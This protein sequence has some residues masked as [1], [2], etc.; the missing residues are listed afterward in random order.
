MLTLH[1]VSPSGRDRSCDAAAGLRRPAP[2]VAAALLGLTL[3]LAAPAAADPPT[4]NGLFY[5]DGDSSKYVEY[6]T[7]YLGS[8]L[9]ISYDAPTATLYTALVV[10][11]NV[12]DNVFGQPDGGTTYMASVGW[13]NGSGQQ[14]GA[15]KL[16][17]SEFAQFTFACAPGSPNQWTWYQ[18]Y[19]CLSGGSW[20]S[21]MSC[22][23]SSGAAPP[24]YTSASS[25]AWN[26]NTYQAAP[27]PKPWNREVRGTRLRDWVSPFD[28]AQT[29]PLALGLDGY[30][31][32]A[33]AGFSDLYQYEWRMVY[34]WSVPLGPGGADCGGNLLYV[35]TGLSHHSPLK[36]ELGVPPP[37]C[38]D[39]END[40][41][42]G[43]I[44]TADPLSDWGD[45]PDGYGT[46]AASG[47]PYHI[48][49]VNGPYLGQEIVFELDGQ[50]S[51]DGLGDGAEEDGV[52]A[53]IDGNWTVGSIR[54]FEVEVS[55]AASGALLG[56][57]LDW[58]GDGDVADAGEFYSW[59]VVEGTNTLA[60]TVGSGFD[61]AV[62]TLHAR[63]RLFSG[64]AAAPGGSLDQSDSIGVATDGEVEDWVWNP[65]TLPVT[66]NAF[67]SS[68]SPD[69]E[70]T[71]SWQT[72]SE[73]DNVG[74]E[75]WGLAGDGW[76]RLG[77][78]VPSLDTESHL[79]TDY[80]VAVA[81]PSGLTH[82]Q[83]VDFST[84][85]AVEEY[86]PFRLGRR[87]GEVQPVRRVDWAP[88]RLERERRLADRGF[89]PV[90]GG[91]DGAQVI[92]KRVAA[93]GAGAAPGGREGAVREVGTADAAGVAKRTITV[94]EGPQTHIAVTE[95]GIQRVTYETLRD[96][97][98]DLAGVPS[99][100]IAV[101]RRGSP[102]A[103][104]VD[105]GKVFGPGSAIEFVGRPPAGDEALYIAA[106]HYQVSVDRRLA[107]EARQVPWAAT[108]QVSPSRI[109]Q[110]V[111][112]RPVK[113]H[114]QSPT[115][116]PWVERTVLARNTVPATA[117]LEVEVAG[118]VLDGDHRL[119]LELGTISDLPD[120]VGPGGAVL[121]EHNVEVWFSGPGGGP[122]SV[123]TSSASGQQPWR[124][125]ADLPSGMLGPGLNRIELRF[126]TDYPFSLVVVDRTRLEYRTSYRG[127]E[128]DFAPDP[129][130][131]GYRVAGFA[132]PN[133]V[134]YSEPVAGRLTR[135]QVEVRPADGGF[136][137]ELRQR[138]VPMNGSPD[139]DS[140]LPE[141]FWVTE[142]PR[143]PAVFTTE[144]PGDLLAGD[145]DLVVV[146]GSSFVGAPAL[147]AYLAERAELHP[148]VVD[149]EDVYNAFGW[150][151]ALPSA[152]T[153]FLAARRVDSPF[154]HVQLVGSDCFDRLNHIS[155]CVSF[156]PLPTAPV[157]PTLYSPSQNRLA[158][159]DGDG[160]A[161]VAV[162]QFS[163]RTEA[164]LATIVDKGRSWRSSGLSA[165]NTALMIAEEGDGGHDFLAQIHRV[166]GHLDAAL[167]EVL[168]M[169][170]HPDVATA[171]EALRTSL[172]AGRAVTVFS[173]HSSS[174][175][176]AYRGLLTPASA[177]ALTNT[178]RPTLMVPLACE[179]TYDISP[180]ADVLGH[181]LLFAGE[182][183]A[184]AISGAVSLAGLDDN[185][186]MA[187]HVL[188]GLAS[189]L[190]LGEA[191]QAG[192]E[193]LG[194]LYQTLQDNWVTQGDSAL[195]M[196]R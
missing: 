195:R 74:F 82:L 91:A 59:S 101:S 116:D 78:F 131:H 138:R 45:L 196:D 85:G 35:V 54:S 174:V 87:Y 49:R 114:S 8:K 146:A 129:A 38:G 56:G 42:P 90:A 34:E 179:S 153:D 125:E 145:A 24:G 171:R 149:V 190:T 52:T 103:R 36:E 130:A 67:A 19:A 136:V 62:D 61:W 115:G 177:A 148:V 48:I 102:V 33:G 121:P 167:T 70:I 132:S 43:D 110:V 119:T 166:S 165:G 111:L 80:S 137:A 183:G 154:T 73:T 13:G 9:Y 175:I 25:F 5:G 109:G 113:Y 147:E 60:V 83:L 181:Q 40:C 63:F 28:P 192:R 22:P 140:A 159:L 178:G 94:R 188:A 77:D 65:G 156:V 96:G 99:R 69:G 170:L 186:K 141:R 71:V 117:I 176:W 68:G 127:P 106:E 184:L 50:P 47:G 133:V 118:E 194:G 158:D 151:M 162:G 185:E 1:T 173:G 161:D 86:G 15:N 12:N 150:G 46:T 134:A 97:G 75:L 4:V 182:Q 21:D 123:A 55:N 164:E 104:W 20:V 189:G 89:R 26:M 84:R 10:A 58:N 152:I 160:V 57:W 92:W 76:Q 187:G 51:V 107:V 14:R 191:V 17:D 157:I 72:A 2:C 168:D 3:V 122:V 126:T 88:V 44:T 39:P 100:E 163:V 7:S 142:T 30:P 180:S 169:A 41:F 124:V 120:L 112:D 139:A 31:S 64:A 172:D 155:Q 95:A 143:S 79:P 32:L 16:T 6:A 98:L 18:G 108:S 93:D 81:A 144:A 11:P 105:G 66:L 27:V 23:T 53:V 37:E 135:H 29:P 128:L 193:A